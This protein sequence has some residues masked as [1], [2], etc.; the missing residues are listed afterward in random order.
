MFSFSRRAASSARSH[1]RGFTLIELLVVLAII[2]ILVALLLPSVRGSREPARRTQCKNNLKQIGLALHNYHDTYGSLP[3]AYTVDDDGQPLHSWR[4]LILP[5][6]EE[7]TLYDQIDLSKPWN[8][9]ANET[10]FKAARVSVY[11]CPSAE[12]KDS[13]TTYVAVVGSE[14]SFSGSEVRS[15]DEVKDG[16][17]NTLL[18]LETSHAHAVP[19]MEPADAD[20]DQFFDFGRKTDETGHTGGAHMLMG[21]GAVRFFSQDLPTA[22]RRALLTVAGEDQ[23]GDF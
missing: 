17:S 5:F 23:V 20:A 12:L 22:T 7:Q 8:D 3:S 2:G 18:V 11:A 14:T 13:K 10:V 1:P 16:L 19:W 6:L 4:T 9:P 21:D 15:F